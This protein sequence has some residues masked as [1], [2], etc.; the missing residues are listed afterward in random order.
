[1]NIAF[2][3]VQNAGRSQMATAFAREEKKN[4]DLGVEIV[5]GGTD[6]ADEIHPGVREIMEEVG[7]D[8]SDQRP[9]KIRP[10]DLEASDIVVIMGCDAEAACPASWGGDIRDWDLPDPD[11][12][13]PET[14]RTIRDRIRTRVWDLLDEMTRISG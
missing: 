8:L 6:P 3:C 4:R 12:K 10:E 5:S 13:S 9:T 11:G 14:Q 1:M 7:I 2:V